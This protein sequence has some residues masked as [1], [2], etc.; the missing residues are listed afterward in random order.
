MRT[1]NRVAVSIILACA[2]AGGC[3]VDMGEEMLD[4]SSEGLAANEV[5]D[6]KGNVWVL[7]RKIEGKAAPRLDANGRIAPFV[8]RS[9]DRDY[10]KMSD[11]ELAEVL[12]PKMARNGYEYVLKHPDLEL[13]RKI[14][15]GRGAGVVGLP[16]EVLAAAEA[17][18]EDLI[19]PNVVIGADDRVL[20]RDNSSYPMSTQVWNDWG[21]SGTL[22]G[23][24]TMVTAA[25]CVHDGNDWF[26]WP[27]YRPGTD[28]QD[29]SPYAFG[30][31]GCYDVT[32][33]GGWDGGTVS[34]DY[35]V[36][37]F[38]NCGAYP[39]NATGWLGF[40]ATDSGGNISGRT[41][42]I[43]GYPGDKAPYPQIWGIGNSSL[44][45]SI[46]YPARV[47]YSID[48]FNGQSG[49]GVY[50]IRDGGRYVVAIHN[51]GY[52]SDEN[53]GRWL[54]VSVANFIRAYSAL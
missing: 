50:Q 30:E 37:E 43:Y 29:V 23:P 12:R 47:F 15:E 27:V 19:M 52:D 35:A 31:F 22:I 40:Y 14:R 7:N 10:S 51:G 26:R 46:W 28:I 13:V 8:P 39:G 42:Y 2:G 11:E 53:Q 4:V 24:S 20:R 54:D 32:I 17:P 49:S 25:H 33:P 16:S 9:P 38:S 41:S 45:T 21:C 36:I 3:A 5:T 6:A 18:M 34:E 1:I 44:S 48:T